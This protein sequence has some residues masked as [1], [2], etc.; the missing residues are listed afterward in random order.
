MRALTGQIDELHA[1]LTSEVTILHGVL[2]ARLATLNEQ[3]ERVD[4][5]IQDIERRNLDLKQYQLAL[6]EI[7]RETDLVA[8]SF[9]TFYKRR[10]EALF[11]SGR[12]TGGVDSQ[13]VMLTRAR[14]ATGP[15]FPK[16][17]ILLSFGLL[18]SFLVAFS[19]GFLFEYLDHSFKRREDVERVLDL[20]VIFSLSPR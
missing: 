10:E 19:A 14:A 12:S 8:Q 15:V 1:A 9:N 5:R 7:R 16:K 2:G 18:I 6:E 11:G 3:I 20:P 4:A 17:K 13:V